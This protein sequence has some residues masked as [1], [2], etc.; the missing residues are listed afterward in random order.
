MPRLIGIAKAKELIFTGRVLS[1]REA[2]DIGLVNNVIEQNESETAAFEQ[3]INLAEEILPQVSVLVDR[4]SIIRI[5]IYLGSYCSEDGQ[6][7][8]QPRNT[9]KSCTAVDLFSLHPCDVCY[10]WIWQVA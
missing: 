3:A 1:G 2:Y 6:E 7:S 9:G 4:C 5:I 10:R 8:N